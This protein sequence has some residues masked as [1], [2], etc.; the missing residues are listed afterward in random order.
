MEVPVNVV[1][2]SLPAT[3]I[4]DDSKPALTS[5]FTQPIPIP[6]DFGA[7]SFG[8]GVSPAELKKLDT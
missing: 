2:D 6:T 1:Q 5:S 4:F 3:Q 7:G 8:S